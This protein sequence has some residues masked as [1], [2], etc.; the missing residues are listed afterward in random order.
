MSWSFESE[1]ATV[2]EERDF[3]PLLTAAPNYSTQKTRMLSEIGENRR[4][5]A[6]TGLDAP[7]KSG[8][9]TSSFQSAILTVP[10][11]A[12]ERSRRSITYIPLDVCRHDMFVVQGV[13]ISYRHNPGNCATS[14]GSYG[15]APVP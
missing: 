13:N 6:K 12:S 1:Y 7:Q 8:L 15:S 2:G 9:L 14:Y 11:H 5:Q 3:I 10:M 4:K